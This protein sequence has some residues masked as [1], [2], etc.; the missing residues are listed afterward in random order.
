[1]E[2]LAPN[3]LLSMRLRDV[4]FAHWAVPPALVEPHLPGGLALDTFAGDAYLGLVCMDVTDV[5]PSFL[6]VGR[7][8]GE[9]NV[10]T[11]VTREDGPGVHFLSVDVSDP[12]GACLA[13]RPFGLPA[14]HAT[15]DFERR[16]ERVSVEATRRRGHGARFV[17]SYARDGDPFTTD[18]DSLERFL[19]E[20]YRFY[21]A[22]RGRLYAGDIAH[23]PWR[24]FPA[25][26]HIEENTLFARLGIDV[27]AEEPLLHY[28]R[29]I[30]LTAGRV[31]RLAPD[32]PEP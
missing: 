25:R 7:D 18:S 19:T 13:R 30:D 22:R 16:G 20:R 26:A 28:A 5:G 2:G 32:E 17:A 23:D 1:M 31:R 15:I 12:L 10:R 6:P 29:R 4:L 14:H 27:P 3:S 8:Y 24:L 11:Y 9:V 21:Q